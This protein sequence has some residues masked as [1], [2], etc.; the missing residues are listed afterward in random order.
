MVTPSGPSKYDSSR[1][2]GSTVAVT[3]ITY[4][5]DADVVMDEPADHQ[6]PETAEPPAPANGDSEKKKKKDKKVRL[7]ERTNDEPGC[8]I[9]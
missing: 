9:C 5:A 6:P 8:N 3:P 2:D 1:P 7:T 4:N